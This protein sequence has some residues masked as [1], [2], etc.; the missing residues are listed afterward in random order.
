MARDILVTS[1]S[2]KVTQTEPGWENR[3]YKA[4]PR[5]HIVSWSCEFCYTP[6]KFS[7]QKGLLD[8]LHT[9]AVQ[10]KPG[11]VL[12]H[13]TP[14]SADALKI[15]SR[16][17]LES[18]SVQC[19]VCLGEHDEPYYH[20]SLNTGSCVICLRRH[21]HH[22]PSGLEKCWWVVSKDGSLRNV[23]CSQHGRFHYKICRPCKQGKPASVKHFDEEG[24]II[25][26]PK[27]SSK[28]NLK[29]VPADPDRLVDLGPTE[30][31]DMSSSVV[32]E[33]KTAPLPSLYKPIREAPLGSRHPGWC[34]QQD[35]DYP[36]SDGQSGSGP[37]EVWLAKDKT[38][39]W[40][41]EP[42]LPT[43]LPPVPLEVAG[44]GWN[45]FGDRSYTPV[46]GR[47][48]LE[49]PVTQPTS[50]AILPG[51]E[52]SSWW[53]KAMSPPGWDRHVSASSETLLISPTNSARSTVQ[54]TPGWLEETDIA[55]IATNPDPPSFPATPQWEPRHSRGILEQ[56]EVTEDGSPWCDSKGF[57][58]TNTH[59]PLLNKPPSSF[60]DK[61]STVAT[62]RWDNPSTL[63]AIPEP[64]EDGANIVRSVLESLWEPSASCPPQNNETSYETYVP[65]SDGTGATRAASPFRP[66]APLL[67][68]R[69]PAQQATLAYL[70]R[71]ESKDCYN[72]L[73]FCQENSLKSG[74]PVCFCEQAVCPL[75][76]KLGCCKWKT[77]ALTYILT[78]DLKIRDHEHHFS[79]ENP[80]FDH[81]WSHCLTTCVRGNRCHHCTGPV[82]FVD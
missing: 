63:R 27:P 66:I 11:S 12:V 39:E 59:S 41:E 58:I 60:S 36:S 76:N 47:P 62:S 10:T 50:P 43:V 25:P 19:S 16:T 37:P 52:V 15:R 13:D 67:Q 9:H 7:S 20:H 69:N 64:Y 26:P 32:T 18:P 54:T 3:L 24:Y 68:D 44:L 80:L 22:D 14:K 48:K 49:L 55:V 30:S 2:D 6:C 17:R 8:H 5:S 53:D 28:T 1:F 70:C 38:I 34:N 73:A 31:A 61:V 4:G 78:E 42:T 71:H 46:K 57:D 33:T 72:C 65:W 40:I 79:R 74:H 82:T 51:L 45:R 56:L 23:L 75:C 77:N 29:T 81:Y 21:A 35:R